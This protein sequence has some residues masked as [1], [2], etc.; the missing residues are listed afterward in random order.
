ML[1]NIEQTFHWYGTP[2]LITLAA[3]RQT[4]ATGVRPVKG[5]RRTARTGNGYKKNRFTGKQK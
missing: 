3:I 2:D 1:S 4:G 5:A